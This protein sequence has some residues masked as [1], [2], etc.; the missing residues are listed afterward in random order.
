M[1]SGGS[2]LPSDV[3]WTILATSVASLALLFIG[4]R[5]A[6]TINDRRQRRKGKGKVLKSKPAGRGKAKP[7]ARR[8]SNDDK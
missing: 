3:L 8:R 1:E 2:N 7:N 6:R 5:L 4:L